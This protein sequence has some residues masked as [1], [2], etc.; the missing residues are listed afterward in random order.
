MLSSN[1]NQ[2]PLTS[3]PEDSTHWACRKITENQM[4]AA[5]LRREASKRRKPKRKS[6]FHER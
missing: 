4:K 1:L 6:F 3:E 5:R 2:E